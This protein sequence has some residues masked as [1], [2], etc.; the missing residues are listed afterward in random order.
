[1]LKEM[2]NSLEELDD[3][4]KIESHLKGLVYG[5]E[6]KTYLPLLERQKCGSELFCDLCTKK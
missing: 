5:V 2:L 1:M 3:S 6:P 4:N